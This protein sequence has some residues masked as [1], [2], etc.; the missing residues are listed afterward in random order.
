[1][2]RRKATAV[3]VVVFLSSIP[4]AAQVLDGVQDLD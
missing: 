1:M 3:V 4:A 2:L